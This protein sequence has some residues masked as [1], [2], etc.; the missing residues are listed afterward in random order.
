MQH[1]TKNL[2]RVTTYYI[3]LGSATGI[4]TLPP[5]EAMAAAMSS[6]STVSVTTLG[7]D[8]TTWQ[9]LPLFLTIG[10]EVEAHCL[11]KGCL[12]LLLLSIATT[13]LLPFFTLFFLT[14]LVL[15][16]PSCTVSNARLSSETIT[17]PLAITIA[18]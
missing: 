9:C 18:F 5:K 15:I 10:E 11:A 8:S 1:I 3:L 17:L 6:N 16:L 14:M 7:E 13:L 2:K 4:S 12:S